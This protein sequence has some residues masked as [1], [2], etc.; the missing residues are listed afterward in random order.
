MEETARGHSVSNRARGILLAQALDF[1]AG[2]LIL[3]RSGESAPLFSKA[4]LA[5][6]LIEVSANVHHIGVNEKRARN[7]VEFAGK[8][9]N[10]VSDYIAITN[11]EKQKLSGPDKWTESSPTDRV[12]AI[13]ER[14]LAIYDYLSNFVHSNNVTDH[15][16]DREHFDSLHAAIDESAVSS[17]VMIVCEVVPHSEISNKE[18]ETILKTVYKVQGREYPRR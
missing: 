7:F 12:R 1:I 14:T 16:L 11:G 9:G 15:V 4:I 8:I 10:R 3:L 17:F 18:K 13:D 6:A 2:Y 5:R